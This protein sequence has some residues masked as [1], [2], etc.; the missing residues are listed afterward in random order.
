MSVALRLAKCGTKGKPCYRI[1]AA[2]KTKSRDGKFIE[3]LGYFNPKVDKSAKL[4]KERIE[5]W[6]SVG[7]QPSA[8]VSALIKASK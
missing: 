6:L 4:N 1:V 8:A 5:Y 7:A 3:R 2:D